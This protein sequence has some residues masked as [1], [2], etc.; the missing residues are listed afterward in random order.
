MVVFFLREFTYS[1]VDSITE[2]LL[3]KDEIKIESTKIGETLIKL[4]E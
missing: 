3:I 4:K 1:Q 2:G